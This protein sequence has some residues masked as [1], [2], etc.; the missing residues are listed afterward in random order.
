MEKSKRFVGVYLNKLQDGDI[1][2]YVNYKDNNGKKKWI[3]VGK[4]SEGISEVFCHNKRNE[5]IT[6]LRLGEEVEII[7]NKKNK[8][9]K[10]LDDLAKIYFEVA[11]NNK[12]Y[13]NTLSRYDKHLKPAFGKKK[14]KELHLLRL[15][16]S[17][18]KSWVN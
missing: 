14:L 7:K 3:K 6:K 16:N 4:K 9:G 17:K 2:Y 11:K 12:D 13:K 5:I 8:K 15:K 1:T 18:I 10:T